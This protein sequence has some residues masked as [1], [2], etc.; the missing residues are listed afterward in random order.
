MNGVESKA[1]S[2]SGGQGAEE[3]QWSAGEHVSRAYLAL[4]LKLL[5]IRGVRM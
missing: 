2:G 5:L 4:D 1:A 3:F